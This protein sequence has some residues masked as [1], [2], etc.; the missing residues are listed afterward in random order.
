[1]DLDNDQDDKKPAGRVTMDDRDLI[2]ILSAEEIDASSYYTSELAKEQAEALDRYFAK[3]YGDEV[4]GRSKVCTH[5]VEDTINWVMP[6]LMRVFLQSDDLVTVHDDTNASDQAGIDLED[7]AECLRHV[8]FRDN[9]GEAILHDFAFDGLAQRIGVVSTNWEDPQPEAP[10]TIDGLSAAQLMKYEQ[11]PEYTVLEVAPNQPEQLETPDGQTQPLPTFMVEVQRKPLVGRVRVEN[12]P[13]EEFK[14]SRRARSIELA[15]YHAREQSNIYIT[16]LA[17]LFPDK[18][19]ELDPESSTSN[20]REIELSSDPRALARFQNESISTNRETS[21]HENR[22]MCV[23]RT[24]YL[25][26]DYDGDG[27]VELRQIKRVGNVILENISVNKSE[28]T[29][30]SPIRV[31]H[32]LVGRSLAD[33]VIDAQKISTVVTRKVLDSLSQSLTSRTAYDS[34]RMDPEGID[35]LLD[36]D[37]G[38]VVPTRGSPGDVLKEIVTPDL[39]ASGFQILEYMDAKKEQAS[40]VIRHNQGLNPDS[41]TKT[42]TGIDL[43]QQAGGDRIELYARWL[44]LGVEQI[45]RRV[46]D[47]L[48]AHQDRARWIKVAGKAIEFDPR[49]WSDQMSVHIHVA[50]GAANRQTMLSNL[51]MI[52]QSQEQIILNAGPDNPL[53]GW[54]EYGHTCERMVEVM[55]FKNTERFFKKIDPNNPPKPQAPPPDPKLIEVQQ[56]GQIAQMQLQLDQA[57]NEQKI[58][59][60]Q[61][62][63]ANDKEIAVLRAAS[64][65]KIARQQMLLNAQLER[66]KIALQV[67][68]Q[69]ESEARSHQFKT[70]QAERDHEVN[71][72][73]AK[74]EKNRP[75]GRLDA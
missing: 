16:D 65:Q 14:I 5:D 44:A 28:F 45:M 68:T 7:V 34:T 9:N 31:A 2:A 69:R 74:A 62:K 10:E 60:E 57:A 15:P 32:K 39:S 23:L 66:Y 36:A 59:L 64:E 8:F 27:H 13:P 51:A 38:G 53:C 56:K 41:L 33:T 63:L 21:N 12:V 42:A 37:V 6:D 22:K 35:S 55:G 1:M 26:I 50:M 17:R 73:S 18:A 47:L 19:H 11:D 30:W 61:M 4:E 70:E 49:K 40:G 29:T 48:C 71:I 58:Q 20:A 54:E 3:P 25:R 52:K 67:K 24:E 72:A 46:L 75:G 43:L